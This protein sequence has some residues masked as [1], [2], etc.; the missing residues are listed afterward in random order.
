MEPEHPYGGPETETVGP[1]RLVSSLGAGGM[2]AVWRAWD[3]R[4][5]R[6]VAVKRIRSEAVANGR[7]RLR[8]EARAAARINH[9]AIVHIYDLLERE[10]GDW[11]VMELV[12][13]RTLRDVID[14]GGPLSPQRA[15][16]LGGEIADG[17]AEA[18]L[19]GILHRDL[20]TTN[21]MVTPSGR[22]KIL[23]FGLAKEIPEEGAGRQ[24]MSL[25]Q[26]GSVVGTCYAM[27]PEQV[28]GLELSA[29]SDLFSL[30]ALLYEI[31]TGEPPFQG[32]NSQESLARVL[33]FRPQPLHHLRP[34]VTPELSRLIGRMIEK[35]PLQRPGSAREVAGALATFFSPL[36]AGAPPP[37]AEREPSTIVQRIPRPGPGPSSASWSAGE[38]RRLTVVCWGLV[39]VDAGSGETHFLDVEA[40]SDAMTAFQELARE[41]VEPLGGRLGAVQGNLLWMYFGYPQAQEDDAQRAVRAAR[42]IVARVGELAARPA[43][44][45]PRGRHQLAA[46][47]AVHTGPAVVTIRPGKAEQLQLGSML[48]LAMGLQ[49]AAPVGGVVASDA[50]RPLLARSFTLE[51]QEPVQLPGFK[52]PLAVYRVLEATDPR[53]EDSAVFR[54][55]VGR[56][57][58]RQLLFDRFR[59]S[60]SSSGQ[61]VMISGEAGIGK[62]SLVR[63]LREGLAGEAATWLVGYGSP[64]TQRSPLFPIV[65]LLERAVLGVAGES[66]ERKLAA[67]AE[68]VRRH[69]L[70]PAEAVPLLASL[71]SVPAEGYAPL[72]LNPEVQRRRTLE[73][74]VALLGQM[75]ESQ[76]VVLIIEDLHWIDPSTLELL[77]LLLEE[78]PAL[79]LMLVGTFRPEFQPPWRHRGHV[80]QISLSRLTDS[81]TEALIDRLAEKVELPPGMREQIVAKTDG[82]PLFVEELTKAVLETG[83]SGERPDIPSTLDGS[84]LA[85]LDRLGDAKQVAQLA[86]VIGRVF[87]FELLAAVSQIEELAL[88]RG[89][90]DL[91][92]AELIHRRGVASR[93]RYVF[94]HALIQDAAY[95]L[96][97]TSQRQQIH[98]RIARTLEEQVS[99]GQEV[100][101]EILAHHFEKAGLIPQAL[102]Y[103]Q[104]AALRATQRSAYTEALSHGRKGIELLANLP[105]S[106]AAQATTLEQELA[107][108]SLMGVSLVPTQ[109][110]AST[111]VAENAARSQALCQ[112]LGDTPRLVPSLYGLWVYHLLRGH[113]QPSIE[114]SEELGRLGTDGAEHALIGFSARGITRYYDGDFAEA[115]AFMEEAMAAYRP[116]LQAG[117][118]QKFGDE[119]GLLPR[120]Y[121]HWC[122]WFCGQ[123]DEAVRYKDEAARMVEGLASPYILATSLFFEMLLLRERREVEEVH[124]VAERLVELSRE[125]RYPFF[126]ALA[127]CGHGWALVHRGQA[128]HAGKSEDI[129]RGIAQIQEGLAIHQAIGTQLPRAYWLTYLVEAY[130]GTGR[131]EE[132]LAT[133]EEALAL[134]QVQL[135]VYFDAELYRL[136]G[137]LL[138]GIPDLDGAEAA[139][140]QALEIARRQGTP[141]LELRAAVSLGRLLRGQ[142]RAAEARPAVAEAYGRFHEGFATRD[143]QEARQ[144]LDELGEIGEI[145]QS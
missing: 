116:D 59:L 92:Q 80:T 1:Y 75:A 85:R 73:S 62:S 123:P 88:R 77:D 112:Q 34:D 134:S 93:G 37:V 51:A 41:T 130:L 35:D 32:G 141:A 125:Q 114:L 7:E 96:L 110:Y 3:E 66:P 31:L 28:L 68:V 4:L 121:H 18:H 5:R 145:G 84:L 38:R 50:S 49:S 56:E 76:P 94:K 128:G 46:R 74:L 91:L 133:V 126:L 124:R 117:L 17:L 111:E 97:L 79:P 55:L 24:E 64:Y 87:T 39:E 33:S 113:R 142:G 2:G 13:G 69:G 129:E 45:W 139:F 104:Q 120:F 70:P 90:E 119:A 122:V 19:H 99:Q 6:E 103:L 136:R 9:P 47:A 22:A 95:L 72:L 105:P 12:Q 29:R 82:V 131:I 27:S 115:R 100:E 144:L 106:Q 43:L 15:V 78:I 140:R 44:S 86:A 10:D 58:E 109:G 25:S 40:L 63:A 8:R 83:W 16:Q 11:I 108:R 23:D 71:L 135:D 127:L 102:V 138:S 132:G 118:A 21:V 26:P 36:A 67:L 14:E 107:L 65:E 48:D 60:R 137:E 53:S 20:K 81:E 101:P 57:Q 54:D 61:A 42:A 89:L 52:E 143:L 30:G 98:E